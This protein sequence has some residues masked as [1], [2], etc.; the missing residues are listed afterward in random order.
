MGER[1]SLRYVLGEL[2]VLDAVRIEK[3]IVSDV[4]I[5][6]PFLNPSSAGPL[7]LL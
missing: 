3:S 5:V 7:R 4:L 2:H 1:R 6:F